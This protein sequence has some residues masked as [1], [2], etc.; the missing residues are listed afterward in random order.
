MI[1][2]N[3]GFNCP[4]G[5]RENCLNK[6]RTTEGDENGSHNF[7]STHPPLLPFLFSGILTLSC[8]VNEKSNGHTPRF[9]PNHTHLFVF[10]Q[11]SNNGTN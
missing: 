8:H 4:G 9:D 1:Q 5:F 2:I 6:F 7:H 10:I 11:K 3:F